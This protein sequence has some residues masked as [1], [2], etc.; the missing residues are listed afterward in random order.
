[1]GLAF[2]LARHCRNR[3]VGIMHYWTQENRDWEG[4][5][6]SRGREGVWKGPRMLEDESSSSGVRGEERLL[7][8]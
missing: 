1:M 6:E 4:R 5:S 8:P 2:N 7:C 3:D